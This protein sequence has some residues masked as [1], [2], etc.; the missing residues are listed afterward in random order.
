[1]GWIHII[2]EAPRRRPYYAVVTALTTRFTTFSIL[3]YYFDCCCCNNHSA[4]GRDHFGRTEKKE[5][6]EIII[7]LLFL[8]PLGCRRV[9]LLYYAS[10]TTLARTRNGLTKM[11]G[12]LYIVILLLLQRSVNSTT[13]RPRYYSSLH[14][15]YAANARFVRPDRSGLQSTMAASEKF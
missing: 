7:L 3:Y 4:R 6:K 1:M 5:T 11:R 13:R 12:H 14:R 10:L 15:Y 2:V 9:H 8:S